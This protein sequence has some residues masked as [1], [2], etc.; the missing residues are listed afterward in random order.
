MRS[1]EDGKRK[2][3]ED[4]KRNNSNIIKELLSVPNIFLGIP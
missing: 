3:V 2:S 4:G 1:V